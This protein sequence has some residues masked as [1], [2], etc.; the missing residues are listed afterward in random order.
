V[1][2]AIAIAA[3][4]A[5]VGAPGCGEDEEPSLGGGTE[6]TPTETTSSAP[7][8]TAPSATAPP[9]TVPP[10]E[11][12]GGAGDEEGARSPAFF[13]GRGGRITPRVVRVP[14]F[15]AIRVELRSVDG[16]RYGLRFGGRELRAGDRKPRSSLTLD[17][18][19][20]QK[21]IVGSPIG[22]GN[23]VRIEASAEPGP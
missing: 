1:R 6:T 16:R 12:P 8:A 22:A 10:E 20:P 18:L 23:R 13:T 17:G 19:R 2:R 14:P 3:A 11:Q 15:L 7:T 4:A 21:A 5:L 9:E